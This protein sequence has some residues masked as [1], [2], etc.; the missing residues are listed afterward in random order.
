[1]QKIT[2]KNIKIQNFLS[3]GEDSLHL[4]FNKGISLITGLNKDKDSKNG[5]GKTTVLDALYWNIFGNTIRDIKKDKILHNQSKKNCVV[6]LEFIKEN[7]NQN[8]ENYKI[9]RSIEPSFVHLY[10]NGEDITLS[11]MPKTDEQIKEIIGGNE[12]VF[13]NAVIMSL[14]NALPF[15]AQK[16]VEKRKFVEG[17]LQINIFGEMLLKVRSDYNQQ[18]KEYDIE[19]TKFTEQQKKISSFKEQIERNKNN[20]QI[21][22]HQLEEKININLKKIQDINKIENTQFAIE[23]LKSTL[24]ETEKNISEDDKKIEEIRKKEETLLKHQTESETQINQ[25]NS[26]IQ[27]LKS[28]TG[29]CPTCKREYNT[30]SQDTIEEHI[31]EIQKSLDEKKSH[32]T[33]SMVEKKNNTVLKNSILSNVQKNKE[34]VKKINEKITSLSTQ[35]QM[36]EMLESVNND[37]KLESASILFEKD[38]LEE[39]VENFQTEIN[40]TELQIS[41]IQQKLNILESAK[42]VVSEEGVK[43]FIVKKMISLLNQRLNYYLKLLEA[44]CVCSFDEMFEETL[45]NEHNKECSY[46]NFSGGERKR[47]DLAV[48]FTFQD[49]LKTQSGINYSLSIYDEL[50]DSALDEKGVKKV[51]DILKEK[52]EKFDDSVYIISHNSN[53]IKDDIHQVVVLEKNNG[54]TRIVN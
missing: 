10:K 3:V 11:S 23:K 14:D 6:S 49:I 34:F 2:F 51:L 39:V 38:E 4:T 15:M 1:M 19:V 25:L 18:K 30:E 5:C 32:L 31:L 52:T 28:R 20:K 26:E 44:P 13:R 42:F 36:I 54:K 8:I 21:K 45:I 17:I 48:L 53:I 40:S 41:D 43:S 37:L 50:L 46:F 7:S 47:I 27:K 24:E 35:K 16:K 29:V 33:F 9:E 22:I 12:E